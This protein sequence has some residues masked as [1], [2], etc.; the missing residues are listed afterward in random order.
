M[1]YRV[2]RNHDSIAGINVYFFQGH[3]YSAAMV[4]YGRLAF[5]TR[6]VPDDIGMFPISI[7][8]ILVWANEY[9][10]VPVI[11][12]DLHGVRHAVYVAAIAIATFSFFL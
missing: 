2:L 10:K 8:S 7:F 9:R 5:C 12:D 4:S 1:G 6:Q 3:H 11:A